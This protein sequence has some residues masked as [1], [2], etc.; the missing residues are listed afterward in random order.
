MLSRFFAL[1]LF[2]MPFHVV[3]ETTKSISTG[4]DYSSGKYGG[5]T[6]TNIIYIPVIG[7]VQFDDFFL[8]LTVPYI[9]VSS[10][11]GVVARGIGS[12]RTTARATTTTQSGLGDVIASAGYTVYDN[13]KLALD[14]VGNIKFGTADPDKDL[15]TG[16]NDYSVQIDGSYEMSSTS[17]FATAGYK[18]IGAP[19]GVSVNNIAY[20]TLGISKKIGE[21][22]SVGLALDAAQ[23][24]SELSPATRE[25]SVF[26]A[27][28]ISKN[29]KIQVNLMKGF[30]DGSPD[31]GCGVMVTGYF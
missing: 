30:S 27:N 10:A 23:R 11:G 17:L 25:L 8:K 26:Y 28:K 1:A 29:E 7:K 12:F 19:E 2:I 5:T 22:S 6:A 18:V 16:K 24:S 13:D 15:G 20:G 14:L 21:K 9:R 31:F 3:A 4:F